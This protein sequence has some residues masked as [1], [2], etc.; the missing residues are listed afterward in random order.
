MVT[1]T[2]QKED[3]HIDNQK[4]QP[5]KN[6]KGPRPRPTLEEREIKAKQQAA[7]AAQ[8]LAKI[9]TEREKQTRH[10]KLILAEIVIAI[11]KK[12]GPDYLDAI[13]EDAKKEGVPITAKPEEIRALYELAKPQ[14]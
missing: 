5:E 10:V 1:Q 6:G 2:Q 11:S 4:Q 8:E 12:F 3:N 9:R 7:R 14:A 13:L